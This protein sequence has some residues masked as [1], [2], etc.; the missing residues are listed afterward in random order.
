VESIRAL[1]AA[2]SGAIKARTAA[3]NQLQGLLVTAPAPLREALEGRSTAALVAACARLRPDETALADP[4]HATKAAL[5][6]VACHL[7]AA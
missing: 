3:T 1:R 6:V 7:P 4:L 2:R 5:R